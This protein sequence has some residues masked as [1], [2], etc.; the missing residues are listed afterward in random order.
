MK[1]W[2]AIGERTGQ[3]RSVFAQLRNY[4]QYEAEQWTARLITLI[5][6]ALI[7]LV[8]ALMILMVFFF[9]IPLFSTMNNLVI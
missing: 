4:F 6:P 2:I 7:I 8:G 5:E 3:V 9:V 1:S